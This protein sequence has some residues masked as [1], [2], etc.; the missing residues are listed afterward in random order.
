MRFRRPVPVSVIEFLHYELVA[1]LCDAGPRI[2]IF[3]EQMS[4]VFWRKKKQNFADPSYRFVRA[5]RKEIMADESSNG[6]CA[7]IT[8]EYACTLKNIFAFN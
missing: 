8:G 1:A 4:A 7:C 6:W 3:F 5:K 2:T